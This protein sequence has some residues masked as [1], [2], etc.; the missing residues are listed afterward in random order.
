MASRKDRTV[1]RPLAV[2]LTI[3]GLILLGGSLLIPDPNI[4][5]ILSGLLWPLIRLMMFIAIGLIIG[6]IIEATGWTKTLAVLA[7]P[8]F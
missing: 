7:R 4:R 3:S 6:Q 2:S 8:C 1:F 5:Q